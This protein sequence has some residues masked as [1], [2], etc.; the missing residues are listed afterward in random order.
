M[1][2]QRKVDGRARDAAQF[3]SPH[4]SR[5]RPRTADD[6]RRF[7]HCIIAAGSQAVRC[8]ASRTTTRASS[9]PPARW[10]STDV[11]KRLLVIGGGIIGLEMATVYDALGA[12]GD[13]VELL[14]R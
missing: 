9:T 3:V 10:S 8:P 14:D 6:R 1:A 13:V 12:Q 2:K 11:P 5:S 7:E 4:R